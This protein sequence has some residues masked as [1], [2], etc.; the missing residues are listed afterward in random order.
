[1]HVCISVCLSKRE[2][3]TIC[4]CVLAQCVRLYLHSLSK[5]EWDELLC[6]GSYNRFM[7]VC[8]CV[9]LDGITLRE[10][11]RLYL[12]VQRVRVC[13]CAA[14]MKRKPSLRTHGTNIKV[15]ISLGSPVVCSLNGQPWNELQPQS[16]KLILSQPLTAIRFHLELFLTHTLFFWELIRV[17]QQARVHVMYSQSRGF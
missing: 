12:L 13:V 15:V 2:E 1:M 6:S 9:W 7:Y 3:E 10:S 16:L 4:V 14:V 8:G 11:G 17:T 5:Q